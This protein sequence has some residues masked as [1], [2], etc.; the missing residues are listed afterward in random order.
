MK[1]FWKSKTM[2]FG[3][4]L[5]LL[6]LVQTTMADMPLDPQVSGIIVSVIGAASMV[7]RGLTKTAIGEKAG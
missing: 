7:L 6:G 3:F 2:W 1:E 4:V 5:G